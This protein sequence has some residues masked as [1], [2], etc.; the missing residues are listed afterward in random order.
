MGDS[1]GGHEPPIDVEL[2][3]TQIS[4]DNEENIGLTDINNVNK[5]NTINTQPKINN[6]A[7]YKYT[8]TGPF[9][10]YMQGKE[11]KNVGNYNFLQLAKYIYTNTTERE[12]IKNM[13]KKGRNRISIEFKNYNLA[14]KFLDNK[15]LGE[16]GYDIFIPG[17]NISCKGVIGFIDRQF[18]KE[19]LERF[20]TVKNQSIEILNIRRLTRKVL[21]EGKA[22][23]L[24]SGSVCYTF[25]GKLLP[26]DVY[27]CGIPFKVKP[28]IMPV[29]QCFNCFL[30]GHTKNQCRGATK[31]KNCGEQNHEGTC[32]KK[33]YHCNSRD[34]FSFNS[35][36]PEFYRQKQ[37]KELMSL[38]NLTY[39]EAKEK[40]PPLF[41]K[42]KNKQGYNPSNKDFP[43]LLREE[44]T[45]VLSI[46][47][48]R[49]ISQTNLFPGRT[50]K[51]A[52]GSNEKKTQSR[53]YKYL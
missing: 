46:Q 10:V 17:H 44:E 43:Q 37:I 22:E 52:L 39:Y 45:E 23:Y 49:M 15:K 26:R 2:E 7:R 4:G 1:S 41:N 28:F 14:N 29:V 20:S 33:C 42:Q 36:C 30:Y 25:S 31:C 11:G 47:E 50:Y 12:E 32:D 27:I 34:H 13:E 51:N 53:E 16:D 6:N 24:E 19:D 38:D 3:L 9:I 18:S 21:R 48:R 35:V 5:S 40:I 8:D